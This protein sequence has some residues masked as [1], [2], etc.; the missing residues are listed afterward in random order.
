MKLTVG[1]LAHNFLPTQIHNVFLYNNLF[2]HQ[3]P[4]FP[5]I[6]CHQ[7]STHTHP[8][9]IPTGHRS[10]TNIST[11]FH[12]HR[13]HETFFFLFTVREFAITTPK[14]HICVYT[15]TQVAIIMFVQFVH[16]KVYLLIL[17]FSFFE[18]KANF[19]NN[20]VYKQYFER[21]Y[22]YII[23]CHTHTQSHIFI[24]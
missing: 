14:T 13:T 4:F 15:Y 11:L 9:N 12:T 21:I 3:F 20:F 23:N 24:S 16:F 17:K 8:Y 6:S 10:R 1:R 22:L 5:V 19:F 18:N 7:R 2:P